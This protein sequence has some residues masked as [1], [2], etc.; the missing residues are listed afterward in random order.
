M[1]DDE[2]MNTKINISNMLQPDLTLLTR[3]TI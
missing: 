2:G 3:L 1:E